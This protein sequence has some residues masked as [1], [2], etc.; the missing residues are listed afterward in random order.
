MIKK[1]SAIALCLGFSATAFASEGETDPYYADE[2]LTVGIAEPSRIQQSPRG[3]TSEGGDPMGIS[4]YDGTQFDSI[5]PAR[6][7]DQFTIAH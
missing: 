7:A 5:P 6:Q 4:V 3:D 2:Q 1:L